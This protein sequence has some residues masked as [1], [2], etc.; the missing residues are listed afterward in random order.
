MTTSYCKGPHPKYLSAAE[1]LVKNLPKEVHDDWDPHSLGFPQMD[2]APLDRSDFEEPSEV[3]MIKL[4]WREM[5][6][7]LFTRRRPQVTDVPS[8]K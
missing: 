6:K 5:F 8:L 3:P 2:D 1:A 4:P 7:S